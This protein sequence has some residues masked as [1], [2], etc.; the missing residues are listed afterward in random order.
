[1]SAFLCRPAM[2]SAVVLP[3]LPLCGCET[4]AV[5]ETVTGAG[6]LVVGGAGG[7][8]KLAGKAA[9][10]VVGLRCGGGEQCLLSAPSSGAG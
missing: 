4:C 8:V 9:G 1:M 2:L 6:S 5:A 3:V 7:T 10:A